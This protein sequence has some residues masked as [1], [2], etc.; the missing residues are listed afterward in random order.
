MDD[1][2]SHAMKFELMKLSWSAEAIDLGITQKFKCY[3][4]D[5]DLLASI[6]DY[7]V[8]QFDHIVPI[9]KGGS[10]STTNKVVAC[11]LCNFSKRN[12][13]PQLVAGKDAS[14]EELQRLALAHV[15]TEHNK[16]RERL[17]KVKQVLLKY[18][19]IGQDRFEKTSD[20]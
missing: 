5:R 19:L 16:K 13:D 18:G 12:W 3:Y 6:E 7:D 14:M 15:M 9:S 1:A 4:C 10:D 20:E 17:N 8:W 11:K 2:S